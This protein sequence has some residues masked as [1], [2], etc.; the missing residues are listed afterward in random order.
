MHLETIGH[1]RQ[2]IASVAILKR[3]KSFHGWGICKDS[4]TIAGTEL[5]YGDRLEPSEALLDIQAVR[6]VQLPVSVTFWRQRYGQHSKLPLDPVM[7]R[8]P[9]FDTRLHSSPARTLAIDELHTLHLGEIQRVVSASL[10]RIVLSN[11]WQLRGT[12]ASIIDQGVRRLFA[13]LKQYQSD[14]A[15]GVD[16]ND[17]LH[18]L[19]PK[20]LGKLKGR[21]IQ[22]TVSAFF[23]DS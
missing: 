12:N 6:S 14:P 5:L 20:M 11:V 7:H 18:A 9:L 16:R 3:G 21:N 2:L 8:C 1:L 10:W 22:D 19:V 4:C 13:D 17:K 15:N 23:I